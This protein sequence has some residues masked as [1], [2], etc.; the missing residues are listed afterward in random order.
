[1]G[2]RACRVEGGPTKIRDIGTEIGRISWSYTSY[3]PLCSFYIVCDATDAFF[4]CHRRC[5][6]PLFVVR[7]YVTIG[8]SV[9]TY[10][11]L[12]ID[13]RHFIRAKISCR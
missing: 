5:K 7:I 13:H 6:G 1:M 12:I 2:R 10:S 11:V 9:F 4:Y 3:V 8:E